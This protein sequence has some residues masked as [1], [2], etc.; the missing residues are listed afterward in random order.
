MET[1]NFIPSE[2]ILQQLNVTRVHLTE[3]WLVMLIYEAPPKGV[4][5]KASV[6]SWKLEI[7]Q[8]IPSES[9]LGVICVEGVA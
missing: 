2:E 6:N 3:G 5:K 4:S 8:R 9:L 7:F 1:E